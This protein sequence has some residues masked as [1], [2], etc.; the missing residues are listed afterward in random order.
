MAGD[1]PTQHPEES[2]PD[3]RTIASVA[4]QGTVLGQCLGEALA[5][6]QQQDEESSSAKRRKV[7][8]DA[9]TA[10]RIL[11]TFG[12]AVADTSMEEDSKN[13]APAALL[14]GRLDHY[15]RVGHNWRIV[16]D[17]MKLQPRL[18]LDKNRRRSDRHSL[19]K[20]DPVKQ[21]E[22]SIPGKAQILA[23]DDL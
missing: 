16:L 13:P 5:S 2:A 8:L 23:F 15:N 6:L 22:I 18:P 1:S 9:S 10:N 12:E 21:K 4:R 20:V 14:S 19:W 11:Q 7:Q 17:D 3:R